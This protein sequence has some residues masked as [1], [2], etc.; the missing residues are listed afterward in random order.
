VTASISS[1]VM[2]GADKGI[3]TGGSKAVLASE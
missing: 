2:S 1:W 3:V